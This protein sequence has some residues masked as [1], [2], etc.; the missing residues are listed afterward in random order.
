MAVLYFRKRDYTKAETI[1][2]KALKT[3][4]NVFGL[5]HPHTG[6]A[7]INVAFFYRNTGKPESAIKFSKQAFDIFNGLYGA[8]HAKTIKAKELM[9]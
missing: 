6:E 2:L 7:V 8:E 9:S 3:Y 1:Y 4:E 5:A